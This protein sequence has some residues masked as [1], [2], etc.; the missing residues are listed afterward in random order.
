MIPLQK[1]FD[2]GGDEI[3]AFLD[4]DLRD[5]L[6][7]T[8]SNAVDVT[9]AMMLLY[10][11][12]LRLLQST[13]T[14]FSTY[15]SYLVPPSLSMAQKSPNRCY[16]HITPPLTCLLMIGDAHPNRILRRPTQP[17][18]GLVLQR[19]VLSMSRSI[20]VILLVIP[21]D[22]AC[23]ALLD[24]NSTPDIPPSEQGEGDM[25]MEMEKIPTSQRPT[26]HP[27]VCVVFLLL[28]FALMPAT[29]EL[30]SA[31][32]VVDGI[33]A[34]RLTGIAVKLVESFSD[35]GPETSGPIQTECV[36]FFPVCL[37]RLVVR[38]HPALLPVVSF[39][40]DGVIAISKFLERNLRKLSSPR[41]RSVGIRNEDREH[42]PYEPSCEPGLASGRPIDLCIQFTL[43][44]TPFLVLLG[45]W[46]DHPMHLLFDYFEVAMLLGACLL[47]NCVLSDSKT[48]MAEG[49]AMISFYVMIYVRIGDGGVV[50]SWAAAGRFY[51]HLSRES[52]IWLHVD[53]L[54]VVGL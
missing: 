2:W 44:W 19:D 47:V 12:E 5:L 52:V 41:S 7:I 9:L 53:H 26:V 14:F 21:T 27:W 13:I 3:G 42:G 36:L 32:H 24:T 54:L 8:L 17:D 6:V 31:Y 28:A 34:E 30:V 18:S 33:L 39:S 50:L 35:N 25:E 29:A 15:S 23:P 22:T 43:W 1:I 46:T 51:A 16:S 45:W 37:A 20:S 48:N 4:E 40:A 49:L 11:C 38:S 10:K